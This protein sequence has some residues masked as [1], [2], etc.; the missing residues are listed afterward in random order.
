D[1]QARVDK[2]STWIGKKIGTVQC[3]NIYTTK[4]LNGFTDLIK[5]AQFVDLKVVA[6]ELP[7]EAAKM[8]LK[9]MV[10]HK[11]N[12]LVMAGKFES[13]ADTVTFLR[14]LAFYTRS[15]HI[16]QT[17][18]TAPP[19]STEGVQKRCFGTNAEDWAEIIVELFK[20]GELD[21]LCI[22]N[23]SHPG[24]LTASMV[25]KLK[26]ALTS[27]DKPIWFAATCDSYPEGYE[28]D[29]Y[30]GYDVKVNKPATAAN[31]NNQ[32]QS[33]KCKQYL[34]IVHESRK[35]EKPVEDVPIDNK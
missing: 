2:V 26:E 15:I 1:H 31:Q 34:N 30:K 29:A 17:P 11:V 28:T 27:M 22:V 35:D 25:D 13:E 33:N 19:E 16:T 7:D 23:S 32:G 4:K 9:T 3:Q 5:N 21:K 8:L 12:Q 14:Q 6:D 18:Y 20:S 24:Y 10:T